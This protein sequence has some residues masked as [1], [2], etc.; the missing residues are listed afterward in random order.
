MK[1]KAIEPKA[2]AEDTAMFSPTM[3][4]LK[5][6]LKAKLFNEQMQLIEEIE[7]RLKQKIEQTELFTIKWK[8]I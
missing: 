8:V 5:N 2:S 3:N 7:V 4:E 6:S 1:S